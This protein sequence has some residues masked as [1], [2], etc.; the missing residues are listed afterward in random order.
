[1]VQ[2]AVP[3]ATGAALAT[4]AARDRTCDTDELTVSAGA[5]VR[6]TLENRDPIP[7]RALGLVV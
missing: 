6:V 7:A 1:M 2:D 4:L 5:T 3:L